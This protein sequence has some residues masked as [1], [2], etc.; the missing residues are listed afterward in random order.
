MQCA[1]TFWLHVLQMKIL[2]TLCASLACCIILVPPLSTH[3]LT[4]I[5]VDL[6]CGLHFVSWTIPHD[7][8]NPAPT[9]APRLELRP[10]AALLMS[11]D[12]MQTKTMQLQSNIGTNHI[13]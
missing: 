4:V 1:G 5:H 3:C 6:Q 10:S 2:V 11:Q 12:M 8:D 9:I 7:A 13:L